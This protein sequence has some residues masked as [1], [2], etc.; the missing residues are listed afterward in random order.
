MGL[1]HNFFPLWSLD[2]L[3]LVLGLF[4]SHQMTYLSTSFWITPPPAVCFSKVIPRRGML[5]KCIFLHLPIW[6][7][8]NG[9]SQKSHIELKEMGLFPLLNNN[10]FYFIQGVP[11]GISL[12]KF[13]T[14]FTRIYYL[15][16]ILWMPNVVFIKYLV[17][18]I[19]QFP[20]LQFCVWV[21]HNLL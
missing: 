7:K 14:N 16:C 5:F 3:Y 20:V 17:R 2:T 10:L 8:H 12:C 13:R 15:I 21:M 19:W 11:D 6:I 1:S 4:T 18:C 9:S